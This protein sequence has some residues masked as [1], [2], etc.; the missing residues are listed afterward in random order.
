MPTAN[1]TESQREG[2]PMR[3]QLNFAAGNYD[4]ARRERPLQE[5]L[6]DAGK[7]SIPED[8]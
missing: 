7:V 1:R 2:A 3:L 5:L 8:I 6:I 4:L